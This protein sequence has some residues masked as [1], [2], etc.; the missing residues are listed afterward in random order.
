M[1]AEKRRYAYR[2]LVQGTECPLRVCP[3][4]D[5]N[6]TLPGRGVIIVLYYGNGKSEA[7]LVEASSSLDDDGHLIDVDDQVAAGYH[8]ATLCGGCGEQLLQ[9]ADEE[10]ILS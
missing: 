2:Y 4:C 5:G 7:G 6:L 10:Q 3:H 9:W 1:L 8:S